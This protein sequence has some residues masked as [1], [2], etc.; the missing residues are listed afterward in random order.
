MRPGPPYDI[1]ARKTTAL[2]GLQRTS[3]QVEQAG[4]VF[5]YGLGMSWGL[6]YT[7][8]RRLTMLPSLI[9][10]LLTGVSLPLLVDEGLRPLFGFSAPNR[11]Y[12]VAAAY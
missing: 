6:V 5:H 10:G 9:A 7:L 8:L 11:A 12:P 3:K 4:L 2:L 1:A